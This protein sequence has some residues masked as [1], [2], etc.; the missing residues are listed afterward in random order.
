MPGS[1]DSAPTN[2][3]AGPVEGVEILIVPELGS[4]EDAFAS[5]FT[6]SVIEDCDSS[7]F[8]SS[9]ALI[10][11]IVVDVLELVLGFGQPLAGA[12]T[13]SCSCEPCSPS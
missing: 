2:D 9:R 1:I 7:R 13:R 8:S 6:P 3:N 11:A 5:T 12:G 4:D 10:H